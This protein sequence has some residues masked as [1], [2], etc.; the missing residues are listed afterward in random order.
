[1]RDVVTKQLAANPRFARIRD[2]LLR[3]CSAISPI[4]I[5]STGLPEFTG[6]FTRSMVL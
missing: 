5:F 3:N 1:M 2:L 4:F 6:V